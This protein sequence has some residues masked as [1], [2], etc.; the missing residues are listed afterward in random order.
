VDLGRLA[1]R[2]IVAYVYLLVMTRLSGKRAVSQSTSIDCLVALIVGDLIDDVL[3]AEVPVAKFGAAVASIT[4]C[5]LIATFVSWRWRGA[6][7]LLEGRPSLLVRDGVIQTR[8]LRSEQI[9]DE[10]LRYL[11]RLQG[12]EDLEDVHLA[13]AERGH[14]LSVIRVP[15]A[16]PVPR[17]EAKGLG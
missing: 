14:A 16:E 1:V 8:G 13:L 10:E 3:W 2:A 11:L 7:H 5:E 6:L 4:L 12:I 17:G 15:D 9:S